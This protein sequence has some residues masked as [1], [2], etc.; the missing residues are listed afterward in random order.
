MA[1]IGEQVQ[2]QLDT[3]ARRLGDLAPLAVLDEPDAVHQ[4]RVTTRRIRALLRVFRA[5][6]EFGSLDHL[7]DELDWLGETLGRARDIEVLQAL[8]GPEAEGTALAANLEGRHQDAMADV[9][10]ALKSSRFTHLVDESLHFVTT[11]PWAEGA[12]E[13][14]RAFVRN[15]LRKEKRRIAKQVSRERKDALAG[16]DTAKDEEELHEV[17][18]TAR[19]GRYSAETCRGIRAWFAARR[20]EHLQDILG[21]HRDAVLSIAVIDEF[22]DESLVAARQRLVEKADRKLHQYERL[23]RHRAYRAEVKGAVVKEEKPYA[24]EK[25][26]EEWQAT[27]SADE[28][29]VLRQAGTERPFSH[30]YEADETVAAYECRACGSELF[31]SETKF[32]AH[33]GWPAFYAPLAEDRVEYIEDRSHGSVRTEVRCANCGSHLGH[34][35]AG[36]GF[37]TPTNQRYCINGIALKQV[38]DA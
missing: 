37:D 29:R 3:H 32:D 28:Y 19:R 27:L 1:T 35:F 38:P 18:K 34:V 23:A 16:I 7:R 25:S 15:L 33:C 6:F 20:M 21:S 11:P 36:E 12:N 24:V 17:R 22:P 31:R 4:L 10:E 13:R 14:E 8:I 26:D 30:A 2:S 5:C 9:I